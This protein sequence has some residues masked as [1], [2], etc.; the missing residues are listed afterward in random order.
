MRRVAVKVT[1][2]KVD[3]PDVSETVKEDNPKSSQDN[4]EEEEEETTAEVNAP[5][6]AA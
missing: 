4:Q 2:K 3:L 5:E 6:I 1:P